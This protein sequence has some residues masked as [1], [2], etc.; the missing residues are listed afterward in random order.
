MWAMKP[1]QKGDGRFRFNLEVVKSANLLY[2]S[3]TFRLCLFVEHIIKNDQ[4]NRSAFVQ[5]N[6]CNRKTISISSN[7]F[8]F[9]FPKNILGRASHGSHTG[10]LRYSIIYTIS[11][12]YHSFSVANTQT[13]TNNHKQSTNTEAT[14]ESSLTST[15]IFRPAFRL[16]ENPLDISHLPSG[17]P[18]VNPLFSKH[19]V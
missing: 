4:F 11:P 1:T 7:V 5:R 17:T 10:K 15:I 19:S 13:Q 14:T 12:Y 9:L 3:K 6:I 2:N 16:Y 8:F 18:G